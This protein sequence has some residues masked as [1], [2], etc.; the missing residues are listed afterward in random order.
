MTGLQIE[1]KKARL[2]KNSI[3]NIK[4]LTTLLNLKAS[5]MYRKVRE[6]AFTVSE[7]LL[8][9]RVIFGM[10]DSDNFE[11]FK[12]LFTKQNKNKES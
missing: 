11:L 3:I 10:T 5:T 1:L 2:E 6:N 7:A 8:V 9:A 4:G 12:Y